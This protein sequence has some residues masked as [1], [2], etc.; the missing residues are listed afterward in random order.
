MNKIFTEPDDFSRRLVMRSIKKSIFEN[1]PFFS[2]DNAR[3]NQSAQFYFCN[4]LA[5]KVLSFNQIPATNENLVKLQFIF[6]GSGSLLRYD[7]HEDHELIIKV[8]SSTIKN[9]FPEFGN[10]NS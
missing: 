3:F 1:D 9:L 4:A 8:I 5:S 7:F 6:S 2:K 10:S